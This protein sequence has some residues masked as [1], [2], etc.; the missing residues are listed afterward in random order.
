MT[1]K[2]G[3]LTRR[4]PRVPHSDEGNGTALR[5]MAHPH[6]SVWP[7]PLMPRPPTPI[8]TGPILE[9]PRSGHEGN[10]P[11]GWGT[12]RR[13]GIGLEIG[14]AR[15]RSPR[16]TRAMAIPN[17]VD[18]LE[19][20]HPPSQERHQGYRIDA[21]RTLGTQDHVDIAVRQSRLRARKPHRFGIAYRMVYRR[22]S[23]TLG[24]ARK[25]R[26]SA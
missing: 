22:P 4:S 11:R 9:G 20:P 7:F 14:D 18:V 17:T 21:R 6:G 19:Q 13:R 16:S 3:W 8:R 23:Q 2:A 26:S 12:K 10:R 25:R 5:Q 1:P 15:R 24:A